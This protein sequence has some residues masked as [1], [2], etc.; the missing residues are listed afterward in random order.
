MRNVGS[1]PSAERRAKLKKAELNKIPNISNMIPIQR[2]YTV[3]LKL[4]QR[5]TI[6]VK[7]NELDEAYIYGIRFAKFSSNVLPTH[8]YYKLSQKEY[9]QLRNDNQND[10]KRVIDE[11]ENVVELMDLEELEKREIRRREE[12]AMRLIKEREEQM[13][14]EAE[15]RAATQSLLDRLHMLDNI[16]SVPTGVVERKEKT[17]E[18]ELEGFDEEDAD[19]PIGNLPMPIPVPSQE[20]QQQ[21]PPS[22]EAVNQGHAAPPPSYEA[23]MGQE[24][25]PSAPNLSNFTMDSIANLRPSSSRSLQDMPTSQ[26]MPDPEMTTFINPLGKLGFANRNLKLSLRALTTRVG[27]TNCTARLN[28]IYLSHVLNVSCFFARVSCM[29]PIRLIPDADLS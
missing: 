13:R 6:A 15:E 8:D 9:R 1:S 19:L 23:L 3:A 2:Y 17:I 4:L 26:N 24:P 27:K 22:Y 18:E 28:W 11:L 21:Q 16:G 25:M 10:I 5:F 20:F 29:S 14:K 12:E 7:N